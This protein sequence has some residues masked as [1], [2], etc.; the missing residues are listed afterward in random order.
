VFLEVG[1]DGAVLV[2][3]RRRGR[4]LLA[5]PRVGAL[6]LPWIGDLPRASR[7][8]DVKVVSRVNSQ[9]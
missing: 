4:L 5:P 2:R 9:V 7:S 1:L 3:H 6:P 8:S